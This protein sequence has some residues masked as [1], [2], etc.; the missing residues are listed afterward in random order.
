M[1]EEEIANLNVGLPR[2]VQIAQ[3][4]QNLA[5][6]DYIIIKKEEGAITPEECADII[7]Q[8]KAWRKRINE[9]EAEIEKGEG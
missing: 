6:T 7:A 5:D 1:T 2:D 8:R 3:L 4:K 9:L